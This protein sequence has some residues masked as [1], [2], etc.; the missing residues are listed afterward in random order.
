LGYLDPFFPFPSGS[1]VAAAAAAG[2]PEPP[3]SPPSKS[4]S[5][6]ALTRQVDAI[7][8]EKVRGAGAAGG[9]ASLDEWDTR[10]GKLRVCELEKQHFEWV[11][12]LFRL[13]H[14]Q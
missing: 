9:E 3:P 2:A 10:P 7:R 11:N 4:R 12:Q 8:A 1:A 13:G 6:E 14:F 5:V